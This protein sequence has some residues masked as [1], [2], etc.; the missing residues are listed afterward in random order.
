M[1]NWVYNSMTVTGPEEDIT[2]FM[3][4]MSRPR[5]HKIEQEDGTY[6]IG[7]VEDEKPSLLSFWN[8]VAPTDLTEYFTEASS[9][10]NPLNWYVWNID[11][12]GTKWDAG[13]AEVSRD[14]ETRVYYNFETAWSSPDAFYVALSEQWPTLDFSVTWEEEQGFGEELEMKDGEVTV[15]RSWDIPNS[16]QD[17]I[18]QDKEDQCICTWSDDEEEWFDDCPRG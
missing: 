13:H 8:T 4:V 10:R 7:V 3:E 18:D 1:A 14:S 2:R 16:H 17:F 12:W 11:N 15:L 6:T 9:D 5:P